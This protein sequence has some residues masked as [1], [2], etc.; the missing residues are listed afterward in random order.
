MFRKSLLLVLAFALGFLGVQAAGVS[1]AHAINTSGDYEAVPPFLTAGVPPLVMLVMGRDHKLYYEA[2]NDASDLNGDGV[3]DIRYTPD[4]DYYGYF[5]SY[6]CYKYDTSNTRFYPVSVTTDKKCNKSGSSYDYTIGE[7][8]GNFLNYCTMSRMDTVRRVLYGG[9]RYYDGTD[10]SSSSVVLERTFIPQ[11]AHTWGKEYDQLTSGISIASVAPLPE[12]SVISGTTRHLFASTTLSDSGPPLLRVAT[13]QT[14]RIWDWVSKERPVADN[15]TVATTGTLSGAYN[16]SPSNHADYDSL[17]ASYAVAST[18]YKKNVAATGATYWAVQKDSVLGAPYVSTQQQIKGY[19]NPWG[20]D[21][22]PAAGGYHENAADQ[23]NYLTV[24]MGSMKVNTTGDYYFIADG[25]DAVEFI[26]S[27]T[28]RTRVGMTWVK[29]YSTS[30]VN[31]ISTSKIVASAY[32]GAHGADTNGTIDN[33]TGDGWASYSSGSAKFKGKLKLVAGRTYDIE[34]R[35]QEKAGNDSYRLYWKGPDSVNNWTVVGGE[36]IAGVSPFAVSGVSLT[37]KTYNCLIYAPSLTDY[38]VRVKVCDPGNDGAGK[39]LLES[40]CKLYPSGQYKPTG[41]LQ[42]HGEADRMYFGLLSGS[43]RKNTSGGVLRKNISSFKDELN[44]NTGQFSSTQGIVHTINTLRITNFDYGDHSYTANCGWIADGPISEGECRNWGNPIGEMMYETL[45]YFAGTKTPT[46][47]YTYSEADDDGLALPKPTWIDPYSGTGSF[48]YCAKPFMLVISD[49]VPSFDSDQL[50][51][52]NSNFSV[53]FSGTLSSSGTTPVALDVGNVAD[54]IWTLEAESSVT[55]HFVGQVGTAYDGSCAP[56][57]MTGFGNVRGLCPEEPTKQGSF[58]SAAVAYFGRINDL[59]GVTGTQSVNTFAVALASPLPRFEIPVGT[60]TITLVP[61]AKSVGGYGISAAKGS[62]QP[63]NGIVDFYVESITPTSGVFR[64]NFEDVEQGADHDM[65]AICTYRYT[66]ENRSGVSQLGIWLS[67]DYAGGAIIQHQGYT[68]SGSNADGTYLEVRDPDTSTTDDPDY[69]MDTPVITH[70]TTGA[71]QFALPYYSGST[72]YYHK[73]NLGFPGSGGKALPTIIAPSTTT[74]SAGTTRWFTPGTT[75]AATILKNPLWYAAKYGGFEELGGVPN[76]PDQHN[77]WDK[78]NDGDPDAY[79]YVVNPLKLEEQLTK[80]FEAILARVS[81]GTAASVISNSRS[82]EGAIYQSIFYAT[83]EGEVTWIGEIHSFLVDAYGNIRVDTNQNKQLD[84]GTDLIVEFNSQGLIDLWL[85]VDADGQLWKTTDG[86]PDTLQYTNLALNHSNIKYLWNSNTWLNE[87]DDV[88]ILIQRNYSTPGNQRYIFTFVDNNQNMIADGGDQQA[89]TMPGGDPS[90]L[91]STAD[92][93]DSTKIYPYIQ[94]YPPFNPPAYVTAISGATKFQDYLQIQT[95][96]IMHYIR[97]ADQAEY[98]ASASGYTIPAFRNRKVDYDSDGTKETWRLGDII[99]STPTVI[100]RPSENYDLIYR[101]L[102]YSQF[103]T[104]YKNRRSVAYCGAN[105]G[106]FH[107]FNAGFFD[108]DSKKF[109]TQPYVSGT[110]GT[111]DTS[112][113]AHELGSE[114]WAYVPYNLLP[115]LYW[116]T[117]PNYSHIYYCDLKPKIFDAKI[118]T[119]DTGDATHPAHPNG[120]GTVL[121]GGMRLGG[122]KIQ[123]DMNKTDGSTFIAGTDRTMSSAFFVLDIT[124]PEKPPVV[125]AELAFPGAGYT[126][127][128]P[129]VIPMM[130]GASTS[131]TAYGNWYLV[132]GSGPADSAGAATKDPLTYAKSYQPGKLFVVDLVAL[133]HPTSPTLKVLNSSGTLTTV[134]TP[135]T[136]VDALASLDTNTFISDIISVDYDLDFDADAVYFGTVMSGTSGWGGKLRR[137]VVNDNATPSTWTKDSVL[138]DLSETAIAASV[139]NGQ[140]IT[141]AP[142]IAIDTAGNRWI[143]FGTG[144]FFT[145]TDA[146]NADQQS[147]YGIKEPGN[148]SWTWGTVT[149]ADLLDVSDAVIYEDGTDASVPSA[150]TV[151]NWDQLQTVTDSKDGWFLDFA[152]SKERNL[153]QPTLLGDILTFT[154]YVPSLDPCEFEGYTY[155]YAVYYRTGTAYFESVIGLSTTNV[156]ASG[157]HEVLRRTSLGKGLSITPNI[158]TGREEGSKVFVQT[159]TGAIEVLQQSNPGGTKSGRVGW[160]EVLP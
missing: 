115:H 135:Y 53:G 79:F 134:A 99:H 10:T 74:T 4:I 128:Y 14:I 109:M 89:F 25:D 103:Y 71:S 35:H 141:A 84:L 12:P 113:A 26:I 146:S 73:S 13:H 82:G 55:P 111:P 5:D 83:Y 96:R 157:K 30:E 76:A 49:V 112:I 24:F 97:G 137:V 140:P 9:K 106:M 36:G 42:T 136:S 102:S 125:L 132:F 41:L 116:L 126:T 16:S 57:T 21:Y 86:G 37:Q 22:W 68:I 18:Q 122:G 154:T 159:S 105:D 144:R 27:G 88:N 15:G 20:N 44:L 56:K 77:E 94:P 110:T 64:I 60:K 39:S 3:L 72:E 7:W 120:W 50:P 158:H 131:P 152:D 150:P 153:G 87:I 117:D 62:F 78:D 75:T 119:A 70:P 8:S 155:L 11:D 130:S 121:V 138:I 124:D 23:T 51:G 29:D 40:N 43:Y 33:T 61:F 139:G 107:A 47:A 143:Y 48:S 80:S 90:A 63:T 65:D 17:V 108:E 58:Y 81:S 129:T 93:V 101:D 95:R 123:A 160:R 100:S 142:S 114:L 59:S 54:N 133:A 19:G 156:N 127:C 85:D 6:K 46:A 91:P 45:R 38:T 52:V 145:R 67:A 147:Y 31:E 34:F 98:A 1:P 149:R 118:F 32:Y 104:T 69:F 148:P 92:L 66:V 28:L 2:Y 151:E